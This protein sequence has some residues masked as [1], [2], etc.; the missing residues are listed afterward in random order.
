MAVIKCKMCGGDLNLIE[1]Q[2]VAECEYC[3]SMQTVPSADNEKKMSL[4]GRANRLRA[5]CDFDKAAGIYESIVTEFPDEA[6][7][8]WGLVLCKYGIEYVDDPATG[9]KIPT[10]H[11][12]SFDSVMD[13]SDFEKAMELADS[14]AMNVYREEAKRIEGIRKGILEVSEKEEPY[15]IFI[16]YKETDVTGD[17][18]LDSVIAQD[19]YD[20]LTD[21]GYRVFF[22]RITLEDKL[23]VAYEPYIFAALNSAKVMLAVGTKF[24]HYNAVWVKNEWSRYLKICANDK[25]KHLIPC[26]KNL[27]AYDMPKE[28]QH[29]QAQDMGKMGAI[30]DLLRGIEKYI[31]LKKAEQP[32]VVTQTVASVAATADPLL[33]RA[34]MFLED[35]DVK[36]AEIY[37]E[38]ALDAEPTLA[39]AYIGKLCVE[40][41]LSKM[42]H[43]ATVA[44]VAF[45]SKN[46]ANAIRFAT[47]EFAKQLR[48]Y[49]QEAKCYNTYKEGCL[50]LDKAKT[51]K[52]F[53]E[54]EKRFEAMGNYKDAKAKT[55]YAKDKAAQC[56]LNAAKAREQE[57][58]K[59]CQR[60]SE[61]K[62][63]QEAFSVAEGFKSLGDYL[64][65]A[66]RSNACQKEAERLKEQ[67]VLL[68]KEA[69]ERKRAA[70]EKAKAEREAKEAAEKAEQDAKAAAAKA[71]KKKNATIAGIAAALVVVVAIAAV[72]YAKTVVIPNNQIK[73]AEALLA[74]GDF[75][76]AVEAFE[77]IGNQDRVIEILMTQADALI[78]SGEEWDA[79]WLLTNTLYEDYGYEPAL[80]KFN[81]WQY[82]AGKS[83][84]EE[85]DYW[86]ASNYFDEIGDYENAVELRKYCDYQMALSDVKGRD[87][88]DA[89][90]A[91][92][93]LGDYE[94]SKTWALY[95]QAWSVA[96]DDIFAA[97]EY[98]IQLP[99]GF[100]DTGILM[101]HINTYRHWDKT[102]KLSS[103]SSSYSNDKALYQSARV[104]VR[105]TYDRHSD[106]MHLSFVVGVWNNEDAA[107]DSYSTYVD[108]E[109]QLTS[110][111]LLGNSFSY[112][113]GSQD[114]G[115]WDELSVTANSITIY[116]KEYDEKFDKTDVKTYVFTAN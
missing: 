29:L 92:E 99:E 81:Q 25:S 66:K 52:D 109:D 65:S 63:S 32:I 60:Q 55:A 5:T 75:E 91:F 47:P 44:P 67:E 33:R 24:D 1:G 22:S 114:N 43:L 8:Y 72:V 23:G 89:L 98:L 70:K 68:Q 115:F 113:S 76:G 82:S 103:F 15:D 45:N 56:A 12:S 42:E 19:I 16:C 7:G 6:E 37:F 4:F 73:A 94:D 58:E 97:E 112:T 17:R 54:A 80:E 96:E 2:S 95:C 20:A 79:Q 39:E 48:L 87:F 86:S 35:R 90:S 26:Y 50:F 102:Y 40:R 71:R 3:G 59:L 61:I 49:E 64:E 101:E 46:F 84:M 30:Q 77:E 53:L 85:G 104:E 111:K 107:G 83:A 110:I 14:V 41:K 31:P 18:T 36:N 108:Y 57:Y 100:E 116:E 105:Y 21:K 11:R 10:C 106:E 93:E 13:D 28:F 74:E 62:T 51:E 34:W 78:E 38:K 88:D 69:Q 27:D 9:K